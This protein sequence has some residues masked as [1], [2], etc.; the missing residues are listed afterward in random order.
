MKVFGSDGFRSK[1]GTKYMR[2][3]FLSKFS[4]SFADFCNDVDSRTV[5]I[6]RDTR[7]SGK[8]IEDIISKTLSDN[9]IEV[10]LIGVV[11]TPGLAYLTKENNFSYGIMITASHNPASDNGIKIF[12]N[13]GF[14]LD[15]NS[16]KIIENKINSLESTKNS[17]QGVIKV[18]KNQV[19]K[20][21]KYLK[22]YD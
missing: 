16:E 3:D 13:T 19:N 10:T 17:S 14:K 15:S 1:F 9:G 22:N 11:S 6:G 21:I 4:I 12:S 18:E 20:Y 8:I 2:E 7:S 5:V